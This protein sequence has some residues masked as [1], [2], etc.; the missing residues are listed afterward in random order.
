MPYPVRCAHINKELECNLSR[1]EYVLAR[2]NG[3]ERND[4]GGSIA[5]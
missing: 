5:S 1:Y 3:N 2:A 4:G